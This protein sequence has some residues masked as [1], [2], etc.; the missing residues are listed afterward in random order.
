[1]GNQYTN[2]DYFKEV[3]RVISPIIV[4]AVIAAILIGV[5]LYR[6][7]KRFKKATAM[8]TV[9]ELKEAMAANPTLAR[10]RSGMALSYAQPIG[11]CVFELE[12]GVVLELRIREG[13]AE[14]LVPGMRGRLCYKG[15]EVVS[16]EVDKG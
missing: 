12:N 5:M 9:R 16:F 14:T 13:L 7:H 2:W 11:M 8:A 3:L 6:Q 15:P 10:S 4:L 1:M